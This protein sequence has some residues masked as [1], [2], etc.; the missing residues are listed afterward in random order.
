MNCINYFIIFLNFVHLCHELKIT[1]LIF[2]GQRQRTRKRDRKPQG[3]ALLHR[4]ETIWRSKGFR[5]EG[6][7]RRGNFGGP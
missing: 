7:K 4:I 2:L 6:F 3:D 1:F 5:A